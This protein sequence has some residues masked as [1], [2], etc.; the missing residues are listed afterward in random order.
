MV[1]G[2]T[3]ITTRNWGASV[4]LS[5]L[6]MT[7]LLLVVAFI[8][9]T[10]L[11]LT[12]LSSFQVSSLGQPTVYGL[13]GWERMLSDPSIL[14]ALWNTFSLSVVR[15]IIAMIIGLFVVWLLVRTDMPLKRELELMFWLSFFLPTLPITL[16]WI[17]LL[18]RDAGLFNRWLLAL[19]FI[20]RPVFDINSYWGII[21][22]HL[23]A[24][25]LGV[26]VLLLGPAFR[27]LDAALEE[28][29]RTSG[30]GALTTLVRVVVPVLTPAILVSVILGLIRSLE[31]FEIELLLGVPIGLEVYSTK[32]H[33]FVTSEPAEYAP[34]T[35]LSTFF[36]VFLLLL[37]ALQKF[38]TRKKSYRTISGKGFSTRL[39]YLGRWRYPACAFV[40]ILAV[41]I[42]VVPATALL[43]GTFMTEFGYFDIPEPWT[44][45]N[46]R[47]VLA[48]PFFKRSIKNTLSVGAGAA[49]V[50]VFFYAFIAYVIVKTRFRARAILDILSWLPWAIPGILLGLALLWSVFATRIAIPIYGTVY[51]LIIAMVIKSMPVGVQLF[52]VTLHQLEDDLEEASW[53]CGASWIQT[54]RRIVLPLV[55][56]TIIVVGVLIFN[57]AVRDISTVVLLGTA[58][59]QTLA[60]LALDFSLAGEY[61]G[62]TVTSLIMV[63]LVVVAIFVMS[64]VTKRFAHGIT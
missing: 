28:S 9:V 40:G 63:I 6:L 1:D 55:A 60:L 47:S 26:K 3:K 43:M 30:A 52:R 4:E 58:K 29:S 48:D 41:M 62:A 14:S 18:D 13:Q 19:P 64:L 44:L 25:T 27:N 31:S 50:G 5:W 36:L 53:V 37:V 33:D 38:Y 49:F 35:A 23:S 22:A 39:M 11:V 16:G 46:W 7:I 8:V 21:W 45:E 57:S 15:Q 42:T 32:I 59:T 17:L 20:D 24:S 54:Y 10:P 51:L 56:P 2:E 61:G 34:A 12:V